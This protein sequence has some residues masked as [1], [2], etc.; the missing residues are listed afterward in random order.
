MGLQQEQK[1]LAPILINNIQINNF[2]ELFF[3]EGVGAIVL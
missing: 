3:M 1:I 2:G